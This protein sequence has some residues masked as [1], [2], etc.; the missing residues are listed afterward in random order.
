MLPFSYT[1]VFVAILTLIGVG[2]I[3]RPPMLSG[4][5]D[6]DTDMLV[7]KCPKHKYTYCTYTYMTQ[8]ILNKL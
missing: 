8:T 5:S 7:S 3:C 6:F 4:S 1:S 2:I